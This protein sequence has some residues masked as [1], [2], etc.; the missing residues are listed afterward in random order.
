[1]TSSTRRYLPYLALFIGVLALAVSPFFVR[2]STEAPGPVFAFYRTSL[3][4]LFLLPFFLRSVLKSPMH[5][6]R[7][8][9]LFPILGG[10]SSSVDL[11]L[12]ATSIHYTRVANATLLGNTAP[13]WVALVAFWIF[14][15]RLR[16]VFWT[17]LGLALVG[18]AV[19]LGGDLLLH[20]TLGLGDLMA[21]GSSLF[22]AGYYLAAQRGRERLP[23]LR[24][25][26]L[27]NFCS[28]LALLAFVLASGMPLSG[29]N[30][31]TYLAFL[32]AALVTQVIGYF[33]II[34]AL[35]H[36]PA[37]IV[38]PTL[39]GQPVLAALLAIPLVGEHLLPNQWIGGLVVLAGIYLVHK[40]QEPG[41]VVPAPAASI[42][43]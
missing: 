18:A 21:L 30:P 43:Q 26:W 38:S 29:Y 3:A 2:W 17:G 14:R 10:L 19:V 7:E 35:G 1:M 11:I 20:P 9:L 24:Y 41:E 25:I 32:G 5:L 13:L 31:T 23:T 8:V 34:Y 39:I 4:A 22:Y 37:S 40:S 16:K 6:S 27:M 12:W 28:S 42:L 15:E 36:L 33:S